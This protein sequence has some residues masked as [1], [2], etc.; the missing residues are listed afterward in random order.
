MVQLL[1]AYNLAQI[2]F[3]L[4]GFLHQQSVLFG[5]S[6][7]ACIVVRVLATRQK[8]TGTNAKGDCSAHNLANNMKSHTYME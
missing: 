3:K 1:T 7:P 4:E 6:A 5:I 2:R 8:V